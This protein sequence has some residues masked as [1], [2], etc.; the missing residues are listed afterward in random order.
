MLPDRLLDMRRGVNQDRVREA[1]SKHR[2]PCFIRDLFCGFQC[3]HFFAHVVTSSD[4]G[5]ANANKL[6]VASV[7]L[8][9]EWVLTELTELYMMAK[10]KQLITPATRNLDHASHSQP[11]TDR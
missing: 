5:I 11:G 8:S 9:K 1:G 2:E 6:A 3:C 10:R 4:H 7:A